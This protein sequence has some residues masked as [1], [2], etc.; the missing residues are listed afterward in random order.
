M[1]EAVVVADSG[2]LIALATIGQ[3]ELLHALHRE[4]LVPDA[5]FA[6]VVGAGAWRPGAQRVAAADWLQRVTVE[7]LTDHLLLDELGR[8]E[9][10]AIALA[11]RRGRVLVLIDEVEG[12][13]IAETIYGLPVRGILGTL[14]KAKENGLVP[15]VRPLLEMLIQSGYHLASSLVEQV[16]RLC[17]EA[18][19]R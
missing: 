7:P 12:R 4:V 19:S 11:V 18:P 14:T 6:E 8:G 3:L 17:G 2:P 9:A 15:A 1:L 13:R 10:E 16:C 5:V